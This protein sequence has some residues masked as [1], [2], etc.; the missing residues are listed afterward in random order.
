MA[1]RVNGSGAGKCG[2]DAFVRMQDACGEEPME[3]GK[4]R[5]IATEDGLKARSRRCSGL[6][7][8]GDDG[9]EDG[10]ETGE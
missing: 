3:C 8:S 2:G 7:Y 10:C 5:L 6:S 4:E 9:C 1:L